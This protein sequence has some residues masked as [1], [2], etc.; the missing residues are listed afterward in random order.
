LKLEEQHRAVRTNLI[1]VVRGRCITKTVD[2]LN[3]KVP[4]GYIDRADGCGA[5]IADSDVVFG[6]HILTCSELMQILYKSE[7]QEI[8]LDRRRSALRQM[9][10]EKENEDQVS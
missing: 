2:H 1:E 5:H 6:F 3:I 8:E 10:E 7:L 4:G 9:L